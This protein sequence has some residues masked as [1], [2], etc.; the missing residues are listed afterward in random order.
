MRRVQ[1]IEIHEQPWFPSFLRDLA[2]DALQFGFNLLNVYGRVAPLV[3]NALDTTGKRSVVDLCSGGGGPWLELSQTLR[4]ESFP[5]PNDQ[6]KV[7]VGNLLVVPVGHSIVYAESLF[8]QGK[9]AVRGIPELRR[10]ILAVRDRIVMGDTYADA[11]AQL[12]HSAAPVEAPP[13]ATNTGGPAPSAS[14]APRSLKQQV[15]D[16]AKALDDAD[17]ALRR[18]DFAKYG[19]LQKKGRRLLQGLLSGNP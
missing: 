3:Q 9:S 8:L 4:G 1:L 11:L 18:G 6:S 13:K 19:E 12:F 17:A 10:V 14:T 2:T 16:A 15:E 5:M 7:V